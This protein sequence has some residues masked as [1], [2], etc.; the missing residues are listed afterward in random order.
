MRIKS[1]I[2]S[3]ENKI[4]NPIIPNVNIF[5]FSISLGT[6]NSSE[7]GILPHNIKVNDFATFKRVFTGINTIVAL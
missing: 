7:L 2:L 4:E 3:Q 6:S 5:P 1:K